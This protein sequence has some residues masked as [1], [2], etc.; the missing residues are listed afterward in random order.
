MEKIYVQA[1]FKSDTGINVFYK[2]NGKINL[3]K[4]VNPNVVRCAIG[5]EDVDYLLKSKHLET[6]CVITEK[7]LKDFIQ[8]S[9]D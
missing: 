4:N 7:E 3:I 5:E 8:Y 2:Q 9:K 1:L 6:F